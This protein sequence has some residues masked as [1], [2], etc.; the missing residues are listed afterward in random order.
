MI[1]VLYL[2]CVCTTC[3]SLSTWCIQ[4]YT[5]ILYPYYNTPPRDFVLSGGKDLWVTETLKHPVTGENVTRTFVHKPML[6]GFNHDGPAEAKLS[7]FLKSAAYLA[8]GGCLLQGTNDIPTAAGGTRKGVMHYLG[9]CKETECGMRMEG[10]NL[11]M[12]KVGDP[13][14][15]IDHDSQVLSWGMSCA[16]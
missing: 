12:A 6:G 1:S 14:I 8:C 16:L 5:G 11:V 10:A 2:A 3:Y 7:K 15:H 9:Y 4:A 13:R